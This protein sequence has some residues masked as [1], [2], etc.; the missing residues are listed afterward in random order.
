[1]SFERTLF[2]V[3]HCLLL[4]LRDGLGSFSEDKVPPCP[5]TREHYQ[6]GD[7]AY[8]QGKLWSSDIGPWHFFIFKLLPTEDQRI[9]FSYAA[10]PDTVVSIGRGRKPCCDWGPS[11]CG[12]LE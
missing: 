10:L 1:M 5:N 7:R 4:K 8:D 3:N 9:E 2:E 11:I 12:P 6:E